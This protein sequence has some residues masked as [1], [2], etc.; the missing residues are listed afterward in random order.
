MQD[1]KF[2]HSY[3]K[4]IVNIQSYFCSSLVLRG[5]QKLESDDNKSQTAV[6]SMF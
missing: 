2:A 6:G 4:A 3:S 1:L 5:L